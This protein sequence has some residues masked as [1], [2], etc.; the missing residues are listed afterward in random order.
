MM[1]ELAVDARATLGEGSLWNAQSQEL[2]W[3]DVLEGRLFVYD[4]A[5]G[6]NE[7]FNLGQVVGTVVPRTNGD[8]IVAL[9]DGIYSYDFR[10]QRLKELLDLERNNAG[11]RFNDGKCD[12]EGRFWVGSVSFNC[13]IPGAGSLYRIGGDLKPMK[14]LDNLTISNGICWSAE[15]GFMYFID[16]PTREVWSFTYDWATGD[17]ANKAVIIRIPDG[18]GVPDGMTIDA[19][20]ISG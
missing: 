16:S 15:K 18:E 4:P 13:D 7:T 11:N 20:E 9:A 14:M 5:T 17:I 8:V 3:I 1:A 10:R 2:L 19:M 12:P 6:N